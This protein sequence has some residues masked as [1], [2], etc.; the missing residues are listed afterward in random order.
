MLDK[1]ELRAQ[2]EVLRSDVA[3]VRR[4]LEFSN[5]AL[6]R[7][8]ESYSSA[9]EAAVKHKLGLDAAHISIDAMKDQ[10]TKQHVSRH[11]SFVLYST[12]ILIL[13]I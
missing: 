3:N 7:C 6:H 11:T 5:N 13:L 4:R 10:A 12:R 1:E 8:E 9:R 2:I